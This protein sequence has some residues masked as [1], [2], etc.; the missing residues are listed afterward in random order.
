MNE[1]QGKH[2]INP[3]NANLLF[4]LH[5]RYLRRGRNDSQDLRQ[6]KKVTWVIEL[7]HF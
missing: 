7:A 2:L 5:S 3:I 6:I 1:S 4:P